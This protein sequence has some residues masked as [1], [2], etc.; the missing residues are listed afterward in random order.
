MNTRCPVFRSSAFR[1]RLPPCP[2]YIVESALQILENL[3]H[4][5][6]RGCEQDTGDGAGILCAI[7]D[8]FMRRVAEELDVKLPADNRKWAVGNVFMDQSEEGVEAGKKLFED[9]CKK[10][11]GLKFLVW[12]RV[13]VYSDCLGKSARN[14]EPIVEQCFIEAEGALAAD[15]ARFEAALFVLR[16]K[17]RGASKTM[18]QFRRFFPRLPW[19]KGGLPSVGGAVSRRVG[20]GKGGQGTIRRAPKGRQRRRR[21]RPSFLLLLPVQPGRELQGY[22][23]V[24]ISPRARKR[25]SSHA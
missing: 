1:S 21:G 4:R 25:A 12:R 3:D 18:R 23:R 11:S 6:A 15:T 24:G 17:A 10:I 14:C 7:P 13:P 19:E 8:K 16:K 2:R 9:E 22:S 20:E 5:G